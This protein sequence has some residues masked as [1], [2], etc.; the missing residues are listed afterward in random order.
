[1]DL[2]DR[3][4]GN[5]RI[6]ERREQIVHRSAELRG[7]R[8]PGV[9]SVK[10]GQVVLKGCQVVG[11]FVADQVGADRQRLAKLYEGRSQH[12]HRRGQALARSHSAEFPPARGDQH[13]PQ[14]AEDDFGNAE[15]LERKQRIVA[16]QYTGDRNY[17][18]KMAQACKHVSD[19]PA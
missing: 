9:G 16:R 18:A 12:R 15:P 5:R 11:K 4:R 13:Q 19:T 3:C 1:M 17:T 7:N 10:G 2:R 8:G 14:H 6:V